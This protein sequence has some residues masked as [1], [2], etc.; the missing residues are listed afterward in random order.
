ML[1]VDRVPGM[2]TGESPVGRCELG[3]VTGRDARSGVLILTTERL[4]YRPLDASGSY[5]EGAIVEDLSNVRLGRPVDGP[6]GQ[7]VVVLRRGDGETP[8]VLRP[9]ATRS[10]ELAAERMYGLLQTLVP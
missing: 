8:V 3:V 10:A 1:W 6:R 2:R 9:S 4:P 7:F 5:G